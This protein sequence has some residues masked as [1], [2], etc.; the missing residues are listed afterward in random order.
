MYVYVYVH[1][2]ACAQRFAQGGLKVGSR[3]K[4]SVRSP[5]GGLVLSDTFDVLMYRED[6]AHRRR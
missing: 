3:P 4:V 5:G 1:M 6:G 2:S